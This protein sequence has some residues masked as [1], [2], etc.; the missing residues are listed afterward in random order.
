MAKSIGGNFPVGAFGGREEVMQEIEDGAAH[1][2]TYNGNPLVLRAMVTVLRDVLTDD[3][4]EHVENLGER[5]AEGCQDV[6]EDAGLTGHVESV[7]S[8]GIV[9]FTEE[10]ITDYRSY[11]AS[12][13]EEFHENYWF[14]MLNQGALPHPHHASQQWTISVQHD[15]EDVDEH[16]EAFKQIAPRLADEQVD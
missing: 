8:Q 16:L 4:Y 1:Y 9:S 2:G 15:E 12:V 7:N 13:D 11:L 6:I 5:L 10:T 14:A 3:A